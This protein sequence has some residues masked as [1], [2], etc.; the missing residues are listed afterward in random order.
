MVCTSGRS[1]LVAVL[2][3]AFCALIVSS[4]VAVKPAAAQELKL[5]DGVTA[6]MVDDGRQ[7]FKGAGNCFTCHGENAE[8]TPIAPNL[9][10]EKWL[11]I[12]GSFDEIVK[13]VTNGVTTPKESMLPMA[14]RG[15][16]QITDDQVK[17]VAAYVWT[18]CR[19]GP[20]GDGRKACNP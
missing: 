17:A 6:K 1:C 12:D 7:I 20:A 16:S 5:P 19:G 4:T 2:V 15:G 13:L 18:L 8:G 3:T 11:H 9:T 14:P 10:D